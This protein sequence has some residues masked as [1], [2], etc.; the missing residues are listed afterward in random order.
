[1]ELPKEL[2]KNIRKVSDVW[3]K[4]I[5]IDRQSRGLINWLDSPLVQKYYLKKLLV[6]GEPISVTSFVVWV[7][8]RYIKS[9]LLDYGL[10]L[11]CADGALERHAI[12]LNICSKFDA[13]DIS[14]E[15]I[16]IAK[17]EAKKAGLDT[18][19]NYQVADVNKIVLS[20]NTYDIA[21]GSMAV[22][23]FLNLEHIFDEL[24]KSLKPNG[25]FILN[26]FVGPSQFQWTEKQINIANELLEILPKKYKVDLTSGDLKERIYRPSIEFMNDYDPSEAI[27][28]SDIVPLIAKYFDIEERIDYGGTILHILL[29]NI[30]GNFDPSK[31]EDIAILRL[32]AY[33][34]EILIKETF[35]T[36]ED[37]HEHENN[38]VFSYQKVLPSDF[39]IIV[40][41]NNK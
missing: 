18:Y 35:M 34:E 20:K 15:S 33:M 3:D 21:F 13:Y 16:K 36:H 40:A 29:Q 2:E 24:R 7:K 12:T 28:S 6:N 5:K 38:K 25:L 14:G 23:H 41:R 8:E 26:E 11:G 22:H 4:M 27:R 30:V 32:L 37:P 1:M 10:S 9:K 39:A 19:I 17:K 31:E